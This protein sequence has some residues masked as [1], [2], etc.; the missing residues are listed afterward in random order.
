[1]SEPPTFAPR[2][3]AVLFDLDDT[4][5]PERRFVDGGFAAVAR[6]LAPR[7]GRTA[8]ELT[9]RLIAL[10]EEQGRGRL[11]D[12]LLAELGAFPEPAD[13]RDL[14]LTSILV[15]RTHDP[16]LEPFPGVIDAL[17]AL[18]DA[19]IRTGLVSDGHAATQHRKLDA[20]AGVRPLL[21]VVVMTDDIGPD[22]AKPS[23]SPFR[24]ACLLLQVDPS[25]AV[26]VANDRRKDF[27]G[28]RAAGLRTIR[29]GRP[30][31]EGRATM[32]AERASD[33]EDAD[34]V[35][36]G[37]TDALAALLGQGGEP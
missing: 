23:P 24:I 18:R 22:G 37:I 10:H 9:A 13:R 35:V 2:P 29:V 6:F 19:G 34:L 32:S 26:Y 1:M 5:Y 8:G 14:V 7:V 16:E 31:D 36:D 33:G 25:S 27:I 28:A 3:A 4:L 12:T 21:D 17:D 20:L 30:P 11:F 15:Y